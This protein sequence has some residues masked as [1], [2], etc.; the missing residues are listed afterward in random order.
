VRFK[1]VPLPIGHGA[2]TIFPLTKCTTRTKQNIHVETLPAKLPLLER[3]G[4]KYFVSRSKRKTQATS[5]DEVHILNELERQGLARVQLWCVTRAAI[6]GA[7]SGGASAWAELAAE[8]SLP[9][10]A[11]LWSRQALPYW[12]ILGGV[13]VV[14]ALM[15]IIFL[16]WDTLRSVHELSRVAGLPL[17]ENESDTALAQSLARAALELPNPVQLNPRVNPHRESSKLKLVLLGLAYKAKVGVTNFLAKLILRRVAGRAALRGVLGALVPFMAVPVTAIWNAFV[18]YKLL[19]EARIRAM[20]PSAISDL[21]S[22]YSKQLS[23]LSVLG[24]DTAARAVASAI[25]RKEDLHPNLNFMFRQLLVVLKDERTD[26][27][28][29]VAQFQ[30]QLRQLPPQEKQMCLVLLAGACVADGR[31][32][33][34]EET[35]WKQC[36]SATNEVSLISVCNGFVEGRGIYVGA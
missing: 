6:A 16:F 3:L 4:I 35:L 26:A 8:S 13:T 28:D 21:F 11:S 12:T 10:G 19:K 31:V 15:E 17:F 36:S 7:L 29:D 32:T 23:H 9:T 25:V 33:K 20:G 1:S 18:A 34:R 27:M 22:R 2:Q 24:K 14:A 5:I 30:H